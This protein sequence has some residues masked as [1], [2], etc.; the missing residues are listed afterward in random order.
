MIAYMQSWTPR[1]LTPQ[2]LPLCLDLA[3]DRGWGPEEARW[4]L[5]LSIGE[6]WGL[7]DPS[8]GLAASVLLTRFP[9]DLAVIGM[10]LVRQSQGRKGLGRCLLEHVLAAVGS[11]LVFLYATELGQPLYE[12]LG[13]ETCETI[14]RHIGCWNTP[15]PPHSPGMRTL[16]ASDFDAVAALD[17]ESFGGDRSRL[18]SGLVAIAD[19]A[20][21]LERGGA[22]SSYG[23]VWRNLNHMQLGPIVA[24]NH[25]AAQLVIQSLAHGHESPLRLDVSNHSSELL[26]W[27][28][29]RGLAPLRSVPLMTL[30]GT[31]MPGDRTRLIATA[32]LATG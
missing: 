10:M 19:R 9:P 5:L 20:V 22:I 25:E 11:S 23:F 16:T 21:V 28:R 13:F 4:K 17:R 8:G 3:V 29:N 31:R 2:D 15:E 1:R 30:N 12:R 7:D 26:A 6:G 32:T 27:V 18:L 24:P 14:V